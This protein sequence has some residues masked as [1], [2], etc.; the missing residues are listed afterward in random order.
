[1]YQNLII[2]VLAFDTNP[3]NGRGIMSDNSFLLASW[4]ANFLA[5]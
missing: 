2:D 4:H 1:M 5:L 3:L